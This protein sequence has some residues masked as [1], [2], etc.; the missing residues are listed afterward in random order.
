MKN[1]I[2]NERWGWEIALEMFF[3]GSASGAFLSI[4]FLQIIEDA[5]FYTNTLWIPL[6][7]SLIG[8]V[9]LLKDLGHP[10]R[11][12]RSIFNIS[13]TISL[14]AIIVSVFILCLAFILVSKDSGRDAILPR[15]FFSGLV[16][17]IAISLSLYPGILMIEVKGRGFVLAIFAPILFFASSLASGASWVILAGILTDGRLVSPTVFPTLNLFIFSFLLAQLL[18]LISWGLMGWRLGREKWQEVQRAYKEKK[19]IFILGGIG[20]I[21]PLFSILTLNQT[22]L[23]MTFQFCLV[24]ISGITLR[25]LLL[26]RGNSVDLKEI[27]Y[28]L[29]LMS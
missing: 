1:R 7:L 23:V 12:W 25:S 11:A 20:T 5:N 6:V 28:L 9:F 3:I 19:E 2:Q 29:K 24:I 4:F 14:G 10:L 27:R 17:L 21:L 16:A 13:S 26:L 8:T 15:P 22:I 18:I